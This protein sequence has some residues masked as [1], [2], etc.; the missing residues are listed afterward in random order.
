MAFTTPLSHEVTQGN[1]ALELYLQALAAYVNALED[2]AGATGVTGAT[3]V[4]GDTGA[5]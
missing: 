3:G 4:Q 2:L 5:V 1:R